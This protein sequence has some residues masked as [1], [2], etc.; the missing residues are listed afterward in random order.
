MPSSMHP[1]AAPTA[2]YQID[3]FDQIFSQTR[4]ADLLRTKNAYQLGYVSIIP[5]TV[6]MTGGVVIISASVMLDGTFSPE[7]NYKQLICN[8]FFELMSEINPQLWTCDVVPGVRRTYTSLY[9][10]I[11]RPVTH[12]DVKSNSLLIALYISL[13]VFAAGSL[14][15][16][17]WYRFY[18]VKQTKYVP[19]K[20]QNDDMSINFTL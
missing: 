1:T 11:S 6:R 4:I 15:L 9:V 17:Y 3:N 16:V 13:S 19:V 8:L 7:S 10:T 20:K 2:S 14:M 12:E 18:Y 5:P